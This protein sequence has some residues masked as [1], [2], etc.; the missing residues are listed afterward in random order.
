MLLRT[1]AREAGSGRLPVV[2][3]PPPVRG[4]VHIRADRCKGCGFCVEFC[5][6]NVL[7]LSREFNAKGFHYPVVVAADGC[8][9]C[10]LCTRL[11]P[12]YAIFSTP[13]FESSR[14]AGAGSVP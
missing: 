13:L 4:T 11:C 8:V 9:D 2:R 3:R 6:K 7:A 1:L 12:E 5:P 14:P 10:K